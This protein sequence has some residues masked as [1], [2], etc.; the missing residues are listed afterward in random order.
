MASASQKADNIRV[1]VRIRPFIKRWVHTTV[2]F[3]NP[4]FKTIAAAVGDGEG[5]WL[6]NI[7]E[8]C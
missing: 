2:S 3:I 4:G 8:R 1:A 7:F 5:V 6:K